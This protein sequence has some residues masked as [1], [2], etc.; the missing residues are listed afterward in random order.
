MPTVRRTGGSIHRV[1]RECS[2]FC[3]PMKIEVYTRDDYVYKYFCADCVEQQGYYMAEIKNITF[4]KAAAD[5]NSPNCTHYLD[6]KALRFIFAMKWIIV[7]LHEAIELL[8]GCRERITKTSC[9]AEVQTYVWK[10]I[11]VPGFCTRR[12]R[13]NGQIAYVFVL[14]PTA[15][16]PASVPDPLGVAGT[17]RKPD[18]NWRRIGFV[19]SGPERP[20]TSPKGEKLLP[21]DVRE[22]DMVSGNGEEFVGTVRE[23][24]DRV[25]L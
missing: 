19:S 22:Q 20:G 21:L 24:C 10:G 15:L 17:G 9:C 23:S 6:A 2:E 4:Y 11:V 1:C 12:A 14:D 18:E 16:F 7:D 5:F 3:Y 8:I 13:S 25:L